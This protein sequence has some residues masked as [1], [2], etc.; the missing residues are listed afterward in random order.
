MC[1]TYCSTVLLAGMLQWLSNNLGSH[2]QALTIG[3]ML[4]G[5]SASGVLNWSGGTL[6]VGGR[7][8]AKSANRYFN[9]HSSQ[10]V[11]GVQLFNTAFHTVIKS[12]LDCRS[13]CWNRTQIAKARPTSVV[14]CSSNLL[15]TR[16]GCKTCNVRKTPLSLCKRQ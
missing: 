12:A 4:F 8:P 2:K 14:A 16:S 7:R 13:A 10:T 15:P 11:S 3:S 9:P 1:E 5:K 6:Y